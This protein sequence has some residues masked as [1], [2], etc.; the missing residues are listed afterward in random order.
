MPAK[1]GS[2]PFR[3][4]IDHYR[5][6]VRLPTQSWTD[7]WE[8]Q[9]A[10]AFVVAGA[11]KDDLLADIQASIGSALEQG[12]TLQQFRK[13]F[14]QIVARHGWPYNGGRNWRTRVIFETNLRTAYQAGRY[15]QQQA[16]AHRRPYWRYKHNDAVEHPRPQHV[17]WDGMVLRHDD[18]FWSTH[19]P[20]N[21]WGCGCRVETLA[22]R[23][24]KRL[25]TTIDQAPP[26]E[27]E[28]KTVGIRGPNPRV[29]KVPKGI[30]PGWGY[31]VG[32]AAWGRNLSQQSMDAWKAQGAKAWQSLTPQGWA[33]AGRIERLPIHPGHKLGSRL[34]ETEAVKEA[35]KQQLKGNEKVFKPGGLPVLVNAETLGDHIDHN[36][37]E[38]LPL[39]NDLLTNPYE[40]WVGFDRHKGTGKVVLRSRIIK[41]YDLGKGKM[42]LMVA[43]A[44]R[45]MLEGWTFL[46]T[47]DRK[48]INRQRRGILIHGEE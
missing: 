41:G 10:R 38:Y 36:R 7:L 4:A 26:I 24:M 3:E 28:E 39:L 12:T 46:P 30:D 44:Q 45:G 1:Y 14:D 37:S 15:K 9:H 18:P 42:L 40:V 35:L 29:V 23:D 48:Y 6:K 16:I 33:E 13:E 19:Y 21:G 34:T 17:A 43:N 20:P 25:G 47:G 31:N 11:M 32:E 27:W 8:G 5:S 22:E 2:L